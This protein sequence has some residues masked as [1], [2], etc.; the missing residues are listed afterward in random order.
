MDSIVHFEI[1]VDN[2][3][4]AKDFYTEIFGWDLQDMPG[5]EYVMANSAPV[6]KDQMPTK[7]GAING[8]LTP[9]MSDTPGFLNYISVDSIDDYLNT[10]EKHNG[11]VI[12]PNT[13]MGEFGSYARFK[14]PEGNVMGLWENAAK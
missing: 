11:S 5:T 13:P 10:I 14:D 9:R 2:M 7:P 4:R 8:G 3:D 12:T 1:P 6:D